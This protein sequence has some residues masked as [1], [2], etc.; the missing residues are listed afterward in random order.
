M[1]EVYSVHTLRVTIYLARVLRSERLLLILL[2]Y[3]CDKAPQ[4]YAVNN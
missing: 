1:G 3:G 4:N 2:T